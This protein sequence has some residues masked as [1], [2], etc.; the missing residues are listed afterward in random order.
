MRVRGVRPGLSWGSAPPALRLRWARLDCDKYIQ[1]SDVKLLAAEAESE[2]EAARSLPRGVAR[3]PTT[4]TAAASAGAVSAAAAAPLPRPLRAIDAASVHCVAPAEGVLLLMVSD[5]PNQFLCASL[6][7]ALAHGLRPTLLGWD[8]S[9]WL[10]AHKKPWS[11]H[12]GAKLVLPLEYLRRC[13]ATI[14][15]STL[16]LFTDHDV[17]FQVGVGVGVG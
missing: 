17:V 5:R 1:P 10:D 6:S 16:V 15:N 11:Y 9:S 4:A 7:S 13:G 12:L 14:P 2:A 3:T 8:P